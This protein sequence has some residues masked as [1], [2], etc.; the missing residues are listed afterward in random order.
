[1]IMPSNPDLARAQLQSVIILTW[2][3][4]SIRSIRD[5]SVR[6]N[7]IVQG[8]RCI[9]F[10]DISTLYRSLGIHL[11]EYNIIHDECLIAV[12]SIIIFENQLTRKCKRRAIHVLPHACLL[13]L[14]N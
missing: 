11:S 13:A 2:D 12:Y 3:K 8:T 10:L 1:M 7:M 14:L 9:H 5:R 4:M 6:F